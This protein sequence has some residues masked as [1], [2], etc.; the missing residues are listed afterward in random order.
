MAYT[1]APQ[2]EV[3]TS[4]LQDFNA[5]LRAEKTQ[6]MICTALKG[7]ADEYFRNIAS[8]VANDPKLQQ[9]TPV[10]LI[11]GGLQ[12]AQLN[13][14]LGAGLGQAYLI[15]FKN[16]KTNCYEAQFQIG[17]KGLVQLAI[18]S[19][20]FL[21]INSGVVYEGMLQNYNYLSGSF[22]LDPTK[23][24]SDKIVGYFA[25]FCLNNGNTEDKCFRKGLFMTTEEVTAHALRYSQT[26]SSKYDTTRNSSK[27][28]TDFDAMAK[29]TVLKLLIQRYAPMS[30]DIQLAVDSDQ[31]IVRQD[32]VL[33][34][35]DNEPDEQVSVEEKKQALRDKKADQQ[36]AI[37]EG[38]PAPTVDDMP[39]MF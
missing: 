21:S 24:T 23:K 33:D 22:D 2:T 1:S 28:T 6:Q 14:P 31:A 5:A 35:V 30:V 38:T 27:W 37:E 32:G 11:C 20:Q 12:A 25:Y 15:P 29:K 34:Y 13:L 16:G 9:C 39:A 8:L 4:T 26:Y 18:R 7:R 17:Y 3:K 19:G 10:S 36:K